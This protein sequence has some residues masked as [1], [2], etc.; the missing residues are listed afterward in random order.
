MK[1]NVFRS[2]FLFMFT[3]I[4]LAG[5]LSGCSS[6]YLQSQGVASY[7]SKNYLQSTGAMKLAIKQTPDDSNLYN[8]LGKNYLA[9]DDCDNAIINL[10]KTIELSNGG[11][12]QTEYENGNE[13]ENDDFVPVGNKKSAGVVYKKNVA[14][15]D[16]GEYYI[17]LAIAY[18]NNSEYA[19]AG[20]ILKRLN[21][22]D[23]SV[24][25]KS[26]NLQECVRIYD[27]ADLPKDADNLWQRSSVASSMPYL[28][29][30]EHD[31]DAA[32]K[33]L[34]ST[35]EQ[36]PNDEISYYLIGVASGAKGEYNKAIE[37][38]KKATK[39][40]WTG[41]Y[42][43]NGYPILQLNPSKYLP[44]YT[45]LAYFMALK[46]DYDGAMSAYNDAIEKIKIKNYTS[47]DGTTY[48]QYVAATDS[49]KTAYR[50]ANYPTSY[51]DR[52]SL[53]ALSLLY[54][55]AGKYNEAMNAINAY[56]DKSTVNNLG[57]YV[58][59][60]CV[61]TY[62]NYVFSTK[63]G[64]PAEKA[65]LQFGD[66]IIEIN[67][68]SVKNKP[69]VGA[70]LK[71]AT[72]PIGNKVTLK[73]ERY[74]DPVKKDEKVILE[75]TLVSEAPKDVN[76]TARLAKSYGIRSLIERAQGWT[77]KAYTDAQTAIKYNP[78]DFNAKLAWGFANIDKENYNEAI[79]ILSTAKLPAN[80]RLYQFD[81]KFMG[82]SYRTYTFIPFPSDNELPKLGKALA[83][84]KLGKLDD[85]ID[86]L[87]S[88]EIPLSAGAIG[89]EYKSLAVE[90]DK[91]S[92]KHNEKGIS[93]YQKGFLKEALNE[94]KIALAYT[95]NDKKEEEIITNIVNLL[96]EYPVSQGMSD[97]ARKHSIRTDVLVGQGNL[98]AG[99]EECRK[100][101]KL[102]PQTA[103]FY[104]NV[105]GISGGLKDYDTAI[106][107]M[108][109]YVKLAPNASDVQEAKDNVTK[110]ELL[111]EN[112][113]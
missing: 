72:D 4:L 83:Y 2:K 55:N 56:I 85:A 6:S 20:K 93:L 92:Q 45:D 38:I 90:L 71:A 99:L 70:I 54:Y 9:M 46:G 86:Y 81:T 59:S 24:C 62:S 52:A 7:N 14:K 103:R 111:Q 21:E 35:I 53:K 50:T 51:D 102:S 25:L 98:S 87:P 78:Q 91:V 64:S 18:F 48:A 107:Y 106:K 80:D 79:K 42:T 73:V 113:I 33:I 104:Y 5:M 10:K 32:I 77:D 88:Q 23:S 96:K 29:I 27:Y 63:P 75:K 8:W 30:R 76:A 101:L 108:N 47:F 39:C 68:K 26:E 41:Y 74:V 97:E 44:M 57:L 69:A 31:Y 84:L 94:Y 37:A 11:A 82:S 49:Y 67:G 89:K 28:L 1:K 110:W 34:A 112:K 65:D 66:K 3:I 60:G 36:Y 58:Y 40:P 17:N 43:A 19:Q 15:K 13:D 12:N 16:I 105:A 61:F 22:I 109:F 100:G 95:N